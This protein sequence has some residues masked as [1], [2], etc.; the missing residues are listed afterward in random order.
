[1]ENTAVQRYI[2]PLVQKELFL[3]EEEAIRELVHNYI[4]K[5]TSELSSGI[6]I[7]EEKY[8]MQFYQFQNLIKEEIAVSVNSSNIDK[9]KFSQLLMEH[10]DDLQEWKAKQEILDSWLS[11]EK[12]MA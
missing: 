5:K 4:I 6:L 9:K 12:G 7:F 3:N 10:E 1:M 2:S 11:M 8:K